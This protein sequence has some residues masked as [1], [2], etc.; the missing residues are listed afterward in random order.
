MT[1]PALE[2]EHVSRVHPGGVAALD[3][4][5]LQ[6]DPG[7][8]TAIVGRSGAGKS[9][10]LNVLGT[11]DRPTAGV[12]RIGGTD[13]RDLTDR[14]LSTVRGSSIGF[15]F[16]GFHLTDGVTA[17]Q[18]VAMAL[19]YSG[20]PRRERRDLARAALERVGLE[21]RI[22]HAA[23]DLSGGERQRVAIARAIVTDPLV[24]LADEPTGALDTANG[25]RVLSLLERL[26]DEG[27]TVVVITHDVELAARLPRRI[28]LRDGRIV[29]DTRTDTRAVAHA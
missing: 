19:L 25:E 24:V 16:Q 3:D 17:E 23:Q 18:N 29:A 8:L 1:T 10:L 13:T 26:H 27:T 6:V 12:V 7:E 11:L 22:G 21:H 2:L 9:T 15:V 14:A 20:V 4:V 28:E 5:S